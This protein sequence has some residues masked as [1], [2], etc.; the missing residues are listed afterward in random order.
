MRLAL[1]VYRFNFLLQSYKK[2]KI[3][4]LDKFT[5]SFTRDYILHVQI[6]RQVIWSKYVDIEIEVE[7]I[8]C[9]TPCSVLIT[10][11]MNVANRLGAI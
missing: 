10:L 2:S 6:L 4:Y 11:T 9:A 8:D 5:V 7:V 3:F 1:V